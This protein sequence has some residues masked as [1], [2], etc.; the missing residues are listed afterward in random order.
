MSVGICAYDQG[1]HGKI[2][3]VKSTDAAAA[4]ASASVFK[5]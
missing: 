5:C 3:T 2:T 4:A 1:H